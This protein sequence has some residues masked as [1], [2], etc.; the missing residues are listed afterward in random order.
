[1]VGA[2]S[3]FFSLVILNEIISFFS[4]ASVVF[5]KILNSSLFLFFQPLHFCSPFSVDVTYLY[6]S[7]YRFVL[8]S[9]TLIFVIR[10]LLFSF[11]IF[12]LVLYDIAVR[13]Y[14]QSRT[15]ILTFTKARCL[16]STQCLRLLALT[17]SRKN[18]YSLPSNWYPRVQ[19]L[20]HF[21]KILCDFY[22]CRMWILDIYRA[23]N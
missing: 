21:C 12:S 11:F 17:L 19:T 5:W 8:Q 6:S 1:M 22:E 23:I 20:L 13:L 15:Y 3:I 7:I 2:L 14:S 18:N 9:S 4:T 16:L 10:F